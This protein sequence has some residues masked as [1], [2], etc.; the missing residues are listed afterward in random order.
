MWD[1]EQIITQRQQGEQQHHA[2]PRVDQPHDRRD[3]PE[4]VRPA[5]GL[6]R[7]RRRGALRRRHPPA[8]PRVH[9]PAVLRRPQPRVHQEVRAEPA[10]HHERQQAGEARRGAHRPHGQ[11]GRRRCRR[12]TRARSAGRRSTSSSRRTSRARPTRRSSSSPRC[13]SSS[14]TS[15]RARAAAR[16]SSRTS[17]STTTSRGTSPTRRPSARAAATPARRTASTRAEAQ[18][19]LRA[20][21]EVYLEGDATGK[22]FVFPKPLLHISEDFFR[23]PGPRG[24]HGAGLP[25]REQAGHHL[26]RLR[27]RRRGHRL[28]VLPAQA[29]AERRSSSTRRRRPR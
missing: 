29:E 8:R 6:L 24:V 2:Q 20:M 14:S 4:G 13:S 18:A 5:P 27:P 15:S 1:V 21:F 19:F 22:T 9:H 16:S 17:T 10:Q 7:G 12:T 25:G 26:L 11:D 23:T 28:A 3:D